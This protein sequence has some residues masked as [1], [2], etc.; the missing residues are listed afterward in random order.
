[1]KYEKPTKFI[2]QPVN[3]TNEKERTEKKN[4]FIDRTYLIIINQLVSEFTEWMR[5]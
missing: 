2:S 1:M 3:E 5:L 4:Y